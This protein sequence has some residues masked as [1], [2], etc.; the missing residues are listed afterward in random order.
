MRKVNILRIVTDH[1]RTFYDDREFEQR[2][3]VG[4]FA[5]FLGLPIVLGV[6]TWLA[7]PR[8]RDLG[9]MITATAVFAGFLFAA[10]ILVLE[11]GLSLGDDAS[12]DSSNRG[13][14]QRF[15]LLKEIRA[16]V[17]Y[18]TVIAVGTTGFLGIADFFVAPASDGPDPYPLWFLTA[19]VVLL[20]HLLLTVVMVVKR[21]YSVLGSE[22]DQRR[23]RTRA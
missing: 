20:S 21:L 6:T 19:A 22:A 23:L 13:L 9:S 10:L 5:T 11:V 4:D 3:N 8:V 15:A 18:T 17:A 16:N 14:Q 2:P 12:T 7:D 1:Y